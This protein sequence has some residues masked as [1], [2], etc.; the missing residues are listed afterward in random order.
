MSTVCG[1]MFGMFCRCTL[2]VAEFRDNFLQILDA[3]SNC[4]FTNTLHFKD[5]IT[6]SQLVQVQTVARRLAISA[7]AVTIDC[8][9]WQNTSQN[10]SVAQCSTSLYTSILLFLYLTSMKLLPYHF[11][12]PWECN[13]SAPAWQRWDP[14]PKWWKQDSDTYAPSPSDA[15]L[16]G[17]RAADAG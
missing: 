7:L 2:Q 1:C 12:L 9:L 16:V 6:V 3:Y 8:A 14:A 17:Q 4:C 11:G 13:P 15:N 10:A 5:L